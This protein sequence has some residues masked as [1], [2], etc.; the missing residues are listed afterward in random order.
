MAQSSQTTIPVKPETRDLVRDLKQHGDRYRSY[1]DIL[2]EMA[3][4]Y[5]KQI[6]EN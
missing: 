5:K 6:E 4:A 1:D 2:E 3:D